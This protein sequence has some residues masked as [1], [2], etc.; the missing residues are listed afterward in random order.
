MGNIVVRLT[1]LATILVSPY[2]ISSQSDFKCGSL[3]NVGIPSQSD[4]L[5]C[6]EGYVVGY[7]YENKVADWVMYELTEAKVKP[8]HE[9]KDYFSEDHEISLVHRSLKSDY[10][11]SDMDRGHLGPNAAL[12]FTVSSQKE[13]FL[14]SNIAPQKPELNQKGWKALEDKLRDCAY[15]SDNGVFVVTGPIW[16][17]PIKSYIGNRVAVPDGFFKVIVERKTPY[18]MSA[19]AMPN[20]LVEMDQIRRYRVTVDKIEQSTGF[21]FFSNVPDNFEIQQES[22]FSEVCKE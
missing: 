2:A 6:R 13:S 8:W 5:L 14:L 4:Q 9:R 17:N 3:T 15:S 21:D 19:W 10:K 22:V 11:Y 7:N 20:S 16:R 18:R 12:D 1:L